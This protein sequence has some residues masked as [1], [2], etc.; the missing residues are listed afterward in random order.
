MQSWV[1]CAQALFLT[2]FLENLEKS[3]FSV[4]LGL[5][6]TPLPK[7]ENFGEE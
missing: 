3:Y 1:L 7:H 5:D 4:R 2:A 6:P